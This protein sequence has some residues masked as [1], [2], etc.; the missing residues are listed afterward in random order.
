MNK[1]SN[2]INL[3][4]F[5]AVLICILVVPLYI[6]EYRKYDSDSISYRYVNNYDEYMDFTKNATRKNELKE[7]DFDGSK[8]YLV[9]IVNM[10]SSIRVEEEEN[11]TKVYFDKITDCNSEAIAYAYEITKDSNYV[12]AYYR[13]RG[14][15]SCLIGGKI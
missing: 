9:Y 4:I 5:I 14:D 6:P 3:I 2:I 8:T 10:E 7:S 15:Y 12:E 1:K 13:L 11:T